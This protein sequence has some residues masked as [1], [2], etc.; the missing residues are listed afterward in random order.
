MTA[1]RR[2]F[3]ERPAGGKV[4]LQAP[5]NTIPAAAILATWFFH[6]IPE[7]PNIG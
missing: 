4:A 3:T 6:Q 1:D 2:I 5:A 7:G